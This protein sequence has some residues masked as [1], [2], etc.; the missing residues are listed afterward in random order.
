MPSTA[1]DDGGNTAS[2]TR[3]SSRARLTDAGAASSSAANGSSSSGGG[4]GGGGGSSSAVSGSRSSGGKKGA[5]AKGGGGSGGGVSKVAKRG[6]RIANAKA[7]FALL[8]HA[9]W[10]HKVFVGVVILQAVTLMIQRSILLTQLSARVQQGVWFFG[11]YV[12]ASIVGVYFSVH[13]TLFSNAYELSAYL[14]AALMS[15]TRNAF[16]IVSTSDDCEDAAPLCEVSFGLNCAFVALEC[17][18]IYKMYPDLRWRKYKAIGADVETREMFERFEWF[19]ATRKLDVSFSV[20]ILFTGFVFFTDCDCTGDADCSED[21]ACEDIK[22]LVPL[23][24]LVVVELF[25][26]RMGA[27][28]VK[29]ESKWHAHW[30]FA[31]SPWLVAFVVFIGYE[32]QS[33]SDLFN[34]LH[35]D[36]GLAWKLSTMGLVTVAAR[37]F[38]TLAVFNLYRHF[39][40]PKYAG[41]RRIFSTSMKERF[42]RTRVT[43]RQQATGEGPTWNTGKGTGSG[44]AGAAASSEIEVDVDVEMATAGGD[45]HHKS[46][47]HKSK[48]HKHRHKKREGGTDTVNPLERVKGGDDGPDSDGGR[49][50][51]YM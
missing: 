50:T 10:Y 32:S 22:G 21:K 45:K 49:S 24:M 28:A 31:L 9:P 14:A 33:D 47:K 8:E 37:V 20:V 51:G 40:T 13:A 23:C 29:R 44:S 42:K 5:P 30:F 26:E 1:A 34:N 3:Q 17:G 6:G 27:L 11:L 19:E 46:K 7:N 43:K 2:P 4:S 48:K 25:W 35:E 36:R 18:F 15:V 39:G 38:T 12:V 41:L 16:E